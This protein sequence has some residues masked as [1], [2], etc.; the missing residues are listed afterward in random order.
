MSLLF[1]LHPG[2]SNTVRVLA[3]AG[4]TD[5]ASM[6][7]TMRAAPKTDRGT[8][9]PLPFHITGGQPVVGE[10]VV[11]HNENRWIIGENLVNAIREH[12]Y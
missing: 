8:C 9:M 4:M 1:P 7:T 3:N 2:P 5:V 11:I 10:G 12:C 6:K